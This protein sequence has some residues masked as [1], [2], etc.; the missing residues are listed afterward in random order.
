[1]TKVLLYYPP[2]GNRWIPYIENELSQ[3]YDL[4]VFTPDS[5]ALNFDHL[6]Q[7]S[8]K[9]DILFSMW[10]DNILGFWT[11]HF[12]DKNI[13]SYIR[14]YE[15]WQ[16]YTYKNID[17]KKVNALIFVSEYYKEEFKR[18]LR[19]EPPTSYLIPNGIDL[20]EWKVRPEKAETNKI[21]MACTV[22]NVKNLPL[23][24]QILMELPDKYT[25]ELIGTPFASQI[26]GQI[27]SYID[28]LDTKGRFIYQGHKDSGEI[29]SWM[30]DKDFILSTSINEGNPNNIIEGMAMG[31]KPVIHN[32]PGALDQFPKD[33]V[34]DKISEAIAI[35]E[36]KY[37]PDKYR[38]HVEN[39][40]SLDNF[41]K[42]HAVIEDTQCKK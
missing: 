7:A 31:I 17:F 25:I 14:R 6:A 18:L 36:G 34:F 28:N 4:L 9:A 30:E 13:I 5:N 35:F 21:G 33:L 10:G 24:M 11:K 29:Q 16:D 42:I 39:N 32:W 2:W 1:M 19:A 37:Q 23:A 38:K 40:Y 41:K 12:P 3:Y 27:F 22:K 15:V 8:E 26:A 20:N